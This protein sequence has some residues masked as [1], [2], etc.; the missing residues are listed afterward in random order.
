MCEMVRRPQTFGCI[1]YVK[2][3]NGAS[4]LQNIYFIGLMAYNMISIGYKES[5]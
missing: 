1:V 3:Y 5:V 2:Q 4:R